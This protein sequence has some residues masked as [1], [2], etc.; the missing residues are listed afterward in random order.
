MSGSDQ[1]AVDAVNFVTVFAGRHDRLC[2]SM[3]I[4]LRKCLVWSDRDL[5]DTFSQAIHWRVRSLTW[6]FM[7]SG[8]EV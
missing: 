8:Y 2:L 1:A 6:L 3:V 4:S 7:S 5:A